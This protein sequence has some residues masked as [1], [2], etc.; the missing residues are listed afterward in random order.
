[1]LKKIISS[2]L[3]IIILTLWTPMPMF[4]EAFSSYAEA[5]GKVTTMWEYE[6]SGEE[7]TLTLPYKG[8]YQIEAYGAQ[9]R[10]SR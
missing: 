2:M 6:Y 1:M 9:G 3:I 10:N 8:I 5:S 4:I 7:K